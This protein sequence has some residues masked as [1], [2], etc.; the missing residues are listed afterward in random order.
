M[1]QFA[2]PAGKN[3]IL[4]GVRAVTVHDKKAVKLEDL[5]A[6]FYLTP[7]D[8]GKNRAEACMGKLQELN[9]S[10]AVEASSTELTEDYLKA[11]QVSKCCLFC[12]HPPSVTQ[13]K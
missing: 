6:Q 3:V 12:Q 4:A 8:V 10:V 1:N 13:P 5:G 7:E 2:I 11:F 9:G